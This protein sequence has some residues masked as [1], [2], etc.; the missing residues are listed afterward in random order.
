MLVLHIHTYL[1]HFMTL[2]IK[3][4]WDN[5]CISGPLCKSQQMGK[6][7]P[8]PFR[9]P[10]AEDVD[11][12]CYTSGTTGTPKGAVI[13]HENLIA[14]VAGSNLNIKFY[15]SDVYISYLPLAHIYERVNQVALLHCGVAVG[16]YQGDNLK[17]MDDLAVL[18]PTVFAS[19]PRLYNRIYAA[20]NNAVKESG[21]LKE[22]LFHS[23]YNAKRQA[24]IKVWK[25]EYGAVDHLGLAVQ[26]AV[27]I[28]AILQHPSLKVEMDVLAQFEQLY[29]EFLQLKKTN[30]V[31]Y[32]SI[33]AAIPYREINEFHW[34]C[35]AQDNE[36]LDEVLSYLKNMNVDLPVC[37][38]VELVQCARALKADNTLW[39]FVHAKR[40]ELV[41]GWVIPDE[42]LPD[43][44]TDRAVF[45][46]VCLKD[47]QVKYGDGGGDLV[48]NIR[49]NGQH[50]VEENALKELDP[51]ASGYTV[52]FKYF[53]VM[54]IF[55]HHYPR[56]FC[57][58][59]LGMH[60]QG[61]VP[62]SSSKNLSH[63]IKQYQ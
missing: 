50:L 43:R 33:V 28:E 6:A 47:L 22:K 52:L 1:C 57:Q 25:L 55:G 13:S 5:V 19:V 17:L 14:N 41:V 16:F 36:Y 38:T 53:Q 29:M 44:G 60:A 12:I 42:L 34:K 23:A 40:R 63:I 18:R 27:L 8:Q 9:P 39:K 32:Q 49:N 11:T 56:V 37:G 26:M 48:E 51:P 3:L 2:L 58:F 45:F 7:S 15:P 21:G 61:C 46:Q 10:K 20:I 62:S 54:H 4:I 59:F 24:I 31:K 35:E 30:P